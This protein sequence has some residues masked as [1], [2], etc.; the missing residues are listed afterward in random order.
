MN[1][2]ILIIALL[3]LMALLSKAQS[4]KIEIS[5]TATFDMNSFTVTEAGND[6]PS[7]IEIESNLMLSINSG[8]IWDWW[9]NSNRKWKIEV[10]RE[11]IS[12][13]D[14]INLEIVRS[15]NGYSIN[16]RGNTGHIYNGTNFQSV[17]NNSSY[18]FG[19]KGLI[20]Y[21]PIQLRLSGF[22]IV[23]GANDY[24]TNVILTIYDD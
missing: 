24:E 2:N 9:G 12:W 15:G 23:N 10:R 14:A 18:F 11:D 7:N 3:M 16:N 21:I 22:S 1:R 17:G 4:M 13:N 19:G 5:G 6:F 20:Y 8:N